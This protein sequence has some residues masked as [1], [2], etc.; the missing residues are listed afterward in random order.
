MMR[1]QK[2]RGKG[3]FNFT[4]ALSNEAKDEKGYHLPNKAILKDKTDI[5]SSLFLVD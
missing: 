4:L 3:C 5:K 1:N 2:S